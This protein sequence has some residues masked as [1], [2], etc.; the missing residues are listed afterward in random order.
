MPI[1]LPSRSSRIVSRVATMGMRAP[2]QVSTTVLIVG[3][4]AS[5][6]STLKP[7]RAK[8]PSR[9]QKSFCMSMTIRM[10]GGSISIVRPLS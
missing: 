7:A 1:A 5:M 3:M 8:A 2:A 4:M 10:T 9:L 6:P